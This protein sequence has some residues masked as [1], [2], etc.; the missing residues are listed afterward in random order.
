MKIFVS[1]PSLNEEDQSS[2]LEALKAGE[3]SGN[4]G[5]FIKEFENSFAA[6]CGVRYGVATSS[7]TTALHLALATLGIKEGD[8]VLVST[9]TNMATFFAVHYTGARPVPIDIEPDTWN[10]NPALLEAKITPKT[11]AIMVVHIYGH[12]VDMNPVLEIA[13]KHNLFVI[14]DAAEAHGAEYEG[15]KIGSLGDIACFSFYANKILTTGEGGMIITK[16]EELAKK[17]RSLGSLAYG[18]KENRFMH[19]SIGFNYRL[20]NFQA[21][22]GVSQLKRID[23]VIEKKRKLADF[24]KNALKEIADIQL[25]VEKPYAKN[26]YWMFH[27][28]LRGALRGKRKEIMLRLDEKGIETREA[29]IPYNMQ[30]IFIEK[31]LTQKDECP[32]ANYAALN[33]F[34]LPSGPDLTEEELKYITNS[35]KEII[36]NL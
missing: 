8:E 10:I 7:G 30:K 19:K 18:D 27:I 17:A 3:I 4:F 32:V 23:S 29:F 14:E 24:Y 6:Y 16:N 11:K 20:T 22:L 25:P 15:K 34:Y 13:K 28:V 5:R 35:L 36:R 12:P 33:G 26:V 31:G 2:V 1:K 9:F 21:A